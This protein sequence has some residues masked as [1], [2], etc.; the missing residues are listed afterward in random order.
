MIRRSVLAA[1]VAAVAALPAAACP[2]CSAQGQ[3]LSG[4][5]NLADLIVLGTLK[6]AKRDP[7]DPSR[8]TTELHIWRDRRG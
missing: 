4:E 6:N 8:G 5:V 3:T 7:D 2:F 1:L